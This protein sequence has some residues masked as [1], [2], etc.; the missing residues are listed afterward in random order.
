MMPFLPRTWVRSQLAE[1]LQIPPDW[2]AENHGDTVVLVGP[3]EL[4]ASLPNRKSDFTREQWR[5]A[6]TEAILALVPVEKKPGW[7][8]L[9]EFLALPLGW[10]AHCFLNTIELQGPGGE[11][12]SIELPKDPIARSILCQQTHDAISLCLHT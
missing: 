12:C 4:T 3:G 10:K 11:R 8:P 9:A 7:L 1:F 2:N 5:A 6:A